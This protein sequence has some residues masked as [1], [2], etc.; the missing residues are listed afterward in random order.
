MTP[1][2]HKHVR[3]HGSPT[4]ACGLFLVRIIYSRFRPIV[5]HTSLASHFVGAYV[6]RPVFVPI[7]SPSTQ[8]L[9]RWLDLALHLGRVLRLGCS[10]GKPLWWILANGSTVSRLCYTLASTT[11]RSRM[12]HFDFTCPDWMPS[13]LRRLAEIDIF[14]QL[15]AYTRCRP[16]DYRLVSQICQL[17]FR[18]G[19]AKPGL[20]IHD[21]AHIYG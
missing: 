12:D 18:L 19:F 21:N 8:F 7:S 14:V 1:L 13:S 17:A 16:F 11:R 5:D 10:E 15:R 6:A 20:C 9:G 3:L 2:Q 4:L